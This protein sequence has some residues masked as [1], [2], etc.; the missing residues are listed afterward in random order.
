MDP[1]HAITNIY[2]QQADINRCW[3]PMLFKNSCFFTSCVYDC[4]WQNYE[5]KCFWIARTYLSKSDNQ[6][7]AQRGTL[8]KEYYIYLMYVTEIWERKLLLDLCTLPVGVRYAPEDRGG[9][10]GHPPTRTTP[11]Y[12]ITQAYINDTC[13]Y[14]A[15]MLFHR[16]AR[17]GPA[18]TMPH[19]T[20]SRRRPP[21][22]LARRPLTAF[23]C[24]LFRQSGLRKKKNG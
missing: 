18:R 5:I 16:H 6:I 7:Y 14:Y 9:W 11:S 15:D 3:S 17:P 8:R 10:P 2:H 22:R 1:R 20:L 12:D 4:Y 23:C 13:A 24:M 19:F 21:A